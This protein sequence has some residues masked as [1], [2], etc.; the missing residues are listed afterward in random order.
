[1][2]S[3]RYGHFYSA[4]KLNP[5]HVVLFP[6]RIATTAQYYND[7]VSEKPITTKARKRRC[8]V[9]LMKIWSKARGAKA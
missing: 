9:V 5:I 8:G 6:H 4:P 2:Q 1:V 7:Q 3:Q